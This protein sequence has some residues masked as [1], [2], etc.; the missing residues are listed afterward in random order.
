MADALSCRPEVFQYA[1]AGMETTAR[2]LAWGMKLL[3]RSPQVQERLRKELMDAGLHEREMTF[4]DLAA[5][6]VPCERNHHHA[7]SLYSSILQT[8][9][10]PLTK[11]F[12]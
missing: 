6:R 10:Q 4:D 2:T 8:S 11:S 7:S 3:S 9:R 12:V 5:D 1:V